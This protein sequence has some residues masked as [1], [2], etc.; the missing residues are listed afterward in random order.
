MFGAAEFLIDEVMQED[1]FGKTG[2]TVQPAVFVVV[3][4]VETV[5]VVA[6]AGKF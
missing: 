2:N 5:A 4:V 1:T 6:V 3:V